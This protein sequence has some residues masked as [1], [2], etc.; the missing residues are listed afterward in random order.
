MYRISDDNY[1]DDLGRLYTRDFKSGKLQW[2]Q[3]QLTGDL[4]NEITLC[5]SNGTRLKRPVYMFIGLSGYRPTAQDYFLASGK[6]DF[7]HVAENKLDLRPSQVVP[8]ETHIHRYVHKEYT[9]SK[10]FFTENK[11]FYV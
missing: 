10:D 3:Y 11:R 6:F 2:R 8:L 1:V 4:R 9:K 7:H 5:N